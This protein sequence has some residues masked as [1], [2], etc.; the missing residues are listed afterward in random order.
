[1]ILTLSRVE[2][3]LSWNLDPAP[4]WAGNKSCQAEVL[5]EIRL[6]EWGHGSDGS[7]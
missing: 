2:D 6:E 3:E 7:S 4:V 1:M 5:I